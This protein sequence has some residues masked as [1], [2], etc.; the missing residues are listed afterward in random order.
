[1]VFFVFILFKYA[2]YINIY[3]TIDSKIHL[4]IFSMN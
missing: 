4:I 3:C 2:I 1:M